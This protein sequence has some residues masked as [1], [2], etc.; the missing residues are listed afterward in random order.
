MGVMRS[1]GPLPVSTCFLVYMFTCLHVYLSTSLPVSLFPSYNQLMDDIRFYH[2]MEVR[3]GDLDPQGHLN[4]A[5]FLTYF[6]QARI[7]YFEELGLIQKDLSFMEIGMIIADIHI[8]YRAPVYLGAAVK[9]GVKTEAIGGK[10]ITLRETVED[11]ST[12]QLYADG[13]V[14]VVTY[15]YRTHQTVPVSREWREVLM[16]YEGIKERGA[17]RD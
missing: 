3:Y 10:S 1:N 13:T 5:K 2:P 11:S 4:N 6:E 15:D 12:G 14:V 16:G 7:R 17:S 8:K 9:V